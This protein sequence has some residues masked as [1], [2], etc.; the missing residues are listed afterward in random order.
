MNLPR[1]RDRD[2]ERLLGEDG[3][4]F[5][6][7][8]RRLS[9]VDPPRRLDRAVLGEAAR[10]VHGRVPRGPRW[11]VGLGSAAGLVLA[12]GIAWQIGHETSLEPSIGPMHDDA[13]MVVPVAPITERARPSVPANETEAA[14]SP[15][16]SSAAAA[17]PPAASAA[18]KPRAAAKVAA[19]PAAPRPT[20]APRPAPDPAPSIAFP[21]ETES[22][23]EERQAPAAA[24]PAEAAGAASADAAGTPQREPA[25]RVRRS[26]P[27]APSSSIELRRDLQLTPAAWLAHVRDLLEH[28]RRQQAS[29]SLQLFRRTHPDRP[30]PDDL[31]P[32]LD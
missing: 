30:V 31:R 4:E 10:A 5:G 17:A 27:P 32:L 14:K 26:A 9:Q 3:G 11:I 2:L 18:T 7:L 22:L 8:Y 6:V 15:S 23:R 29:E 19:P 28:G 1:D 16:A 21:T 25:Q 13:P 12:A 20:P 24:A